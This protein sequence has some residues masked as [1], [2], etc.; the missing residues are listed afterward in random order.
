MLRFGLIG[1]GTHARWAVRAA[2]ANAG[3]AELAAVADINPASLAELAAEGMATYTDYREMI[4]QE[5]LD[6]IYVATPADAHEGPTIASLEA[7]L[8]V[9]CEKPMAD[10][11]AACQRMVDA[12]ERT[13]VLLAIDF[14][15]RFSPA[16]RQ[17][18]AWIDAGYLGKVKA[19][20][21]QQ[22]WD[23][24]KA[25]GP[26]APRRARLTNLAGSL[27][28]SIHQLDQ[29]RYF[30]G[31]GEWEEIHA[32]GMW[33][34]EELAKPP[35]TALIARLKGG[36]LVTSNSSFAYTAY[37]EPV[38]RSNV[39]TIVGTQGVI[40][41]FEDEEGSALLKLVSK[42]KREAVQVQHVGHNLAIAWLIDAFCELVQGHQAASSVL[43]TGYDGL[44]AQVI[45]DEV[46]RQAV[47]R[48]AD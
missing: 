41:H 21:W 18:K 40:N 45:T 24:H 31:G 3:H 20:H 16:V 10:T 6:A 30:S 43:A 48:R 17:V 8:P 1:Y 12:A 28:C 39:M 38:A 4:A 15:G 23:G 29:A 2:L 25:F 22:F 9:I 37:I 13:G 35:H 46:N 36:P 34:D 26:V 27:D 14:E 11:V 42:D 5:A 7:G 47:A 19:I 33:F 44:M 32:L